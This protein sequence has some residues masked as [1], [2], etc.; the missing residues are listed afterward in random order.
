MGPQKFHE[1][2]MRC[3]IQVHGEV[4]GE[5]CAVGQVCKTLRPWVW[6]SQDVWTG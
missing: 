1:A 3:H 4:L 2:A 6:T 5:C